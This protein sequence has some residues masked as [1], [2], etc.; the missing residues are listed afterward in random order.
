MG[1]NDMI[2]DVLCHSEK[3]NSTYNLLN[4]HSFVTWIRLSIHDGEEKR[5]ALTL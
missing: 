2:N 5:E 3:C 4:F 1:L